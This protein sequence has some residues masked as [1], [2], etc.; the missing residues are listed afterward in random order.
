MLLHHLP[1]TGGRAASWE[2]G[3]KS[4]AARPSR[5][6]SLVTRHK[7]MISYTVQQHRYWA[8]EVSREPLA[9]EADA[10]MTQ[11]ETRP[12][13]VVG[14]LIANSALGA[15]VGV[16]CALVI[17]QNWPS[18]VA[19]M[20]GMFLGMLIAIPV[21]LASSLLLG[22]FETM[23]PMMLSGMSSGMLVAMMASQKP[24][25]WRDGLTA[26][27][28]AG[29]AVVAFTYAMNALLTREAKPSETKQ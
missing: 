5:F 23:L 15:L 14:D 6:D 4:M 18:L 2:S 24:I 12:Y 16:C 3:S 20:A 9:K 25:P 1:A 11:I 27:A 26:G 8:D 13:F 21:Q 22:A 7:E 19:M 17:P 10:R 28:L 29:L